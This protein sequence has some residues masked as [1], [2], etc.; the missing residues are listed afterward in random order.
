[1]ATETTGAAEAQA[2]AATQPQ[3]GASP[4]AGSAQAAAQPSATDTVDVAALQRELN[5]A[6]KEAAKY[7]TEKNAEQTA[8]LSAEERLTKQVSD[9]EKKLADA[10]LRDQERTV[11]LATFESAQRLGFRNPE[12]A[13]RLLDRAAVQYAEDGTPRNV[14]A[15][16]S[17]LAKDNA[18][19]VNQTTDFGGG[20]RGQTAGKGDMNAYIR[21]V[22]SG[23]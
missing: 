22:A 1:M 8:K 16:L 7:R 14:E 6:R 23:H 2:A 20:P 4:E 15:L 18:Y 12:L 10:E 17:Q 5:D 9:L 11:R 13:F 21:R 3:A 19:L